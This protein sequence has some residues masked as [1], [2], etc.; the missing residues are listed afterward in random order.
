M[1]DFA[2]CTHLF[3]HYADEL[4][5]L[6][7]GPSLDLLQM[8][9]AFDARV[10]KELV[11]WFI[12]WHWSFLNGALASFSSWQFLF[13]QE[14]SR[15]SRGPVLLHGL[16]TV[17][18]LAICMCLSILWI[19]SLFRYYKAMWLCVVGKRRISRCCFPLKRDWQQRRAARRRSCKG[20]VFVGLAVLQGL[21]GLCSCHDTQLQENPALV[22]ENLWKEDVW[23]PQ[24]VGD[25]T[26]FETGLNLTSCRSLEVY[27]S[28]SAE[29]FDQLSFMQVFSSTTNDVC[30]SHRDLRLYLDAQVL[31]ADGGP[32]LRTAQIWW[33]VNGLGMMQRT[34]LVRSFRLDRCIRCQMDS[35]G[36]F[37][38]PTAIGPYLVNPIT[39]HGPQD[40][41]HF[42]FPQGPVPDSER[43]LLVHYHD[44]SIDRGTVRVSHALGWVSMLQLFSNVR[45]QHRCATTSWCRVFLRG[46][47]AWWPELLL[48]HNFEFV[49]LEEISTVAT[50][51]PNTNSQL[52]PGHVLPFADTGGT[53]YAG[54]SLLQLG[55]SLLLSPVSLAA[56]AYMPHL[57]PDEF[58]A[59]VLE[60][61]DGD[62]NLINVPVDLTWPDVQTRYGISQ[63]REDT[64]DVMDEVF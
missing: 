35:S 1:R 26:V 18:F 52:C 4:G 57:R 48:L 60:E 33:H 56:T 6:W 15:I 7:F 3:V 19:N 12:A 21:P 53:D 22:T 37:W 61:F 42:I 39:S 31:R 16:T 47:Y 50:V 63:V 34:S 43:L 62:G 8:N 30:S 49:Q 17:P 11:E 46:R 27:S 29:E 24:R 20:T 41:V 32:S 55:I 40:P 51:D 2:W 38:S 10:R 45:P 25:G 23:L 58:L 13:V 9:W 59:E 64:F 28:Q 5:S 54:I 36:S 44:G 14:L